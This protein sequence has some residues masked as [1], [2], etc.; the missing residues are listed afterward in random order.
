MNRGFLSD[1]ERTLL[2]AHARNAIAAD[3]DLPPG[4][5]PSEQK[6]LAEHPRLAAEDGLFVTLRLEGKL[7]GCIGTM[8]G[9]SPLWH[10]AAAMA[11]SSAFRDPRFPPLRKVEFDAVS[12]EI[13]VLSPLT[14][15][16]D[17]NVI[18]PGR[19]GLLVRRGT[20]SGVLLPQVADERGWGRDEFLRQTCRKAGL[21]ETAWQEAG[22]EI[23]S[24]EAEIFAER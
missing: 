10:G 22:T 3:L 19:H 20:M 14:R 8:T 9:R 12:I 7:R 24:F 15:I 16:E 17:I 6:L 5:E 1:T 4:K 13:S 23:E 11:R 2:L 21:P 18:E